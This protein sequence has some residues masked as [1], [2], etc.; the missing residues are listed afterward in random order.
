MLNV[1]KKGVMFLAIT[2]ISMVSTSC[3]N[4]NDEPGEGESPTTT[5]ELVNP[6]NV[7]T[8]KMPTKV[9]NLTIIRNEGGLVTEIKSTEGLTI[10]FHYATTRASQTKEE[11]IM[12]VTE[13]GM[14]TDYTLTIGENGFIS[15]AYVKMGKPGEKEYEEGEWTMNYDNDGHLTKAFHDY[16]DVYGHETYS[17]NIKWNDGNIIKTWKDGEEGGWDAFT[18]SYTSNYYPS[19]ID[20][21]GCLFMF[22]AIYPIEVYEFEWFYYAGMLGKGPKNLAVSAT[23]V[24]EDEDGDTIPVHFVWTMNEEGYPTLFDIRDDDHPGESIIKFTW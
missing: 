14:T 3:S 21:K 12:S 8:G 10:K 4:D 7:F 22:E 5:P 16:V 24:D 19:K 15:K 1:L 17:V 2:S 6:A 9:G 13:Y 18:Y 23:E 20:N 11:V